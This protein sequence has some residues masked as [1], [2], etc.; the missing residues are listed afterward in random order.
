VVRHSRQWFLR[1]EHSAIRSGDVRWRVNLGIPSPGYGDEKVR[2]AFERVAR[3]AWAFSEASA[4]PSIQLAAEMLRSERPVGARIAVVPEVVAEAVGY[5]RSPLRRSDLHL[6]IDVGAT[7]LDVCGFILFDPNREEDQY[8]ILTARVERLGTHQLHSRRLNA[9]STSEWRPEIAAMD[10]SDPLLVIPDS[11]REYWKHDPVTPDVD[12]VDDNFQK[13]CV[14]VL[15]TCLHH[16]KVKRYPNSPAWK[17]GIPV[18]LCGGG[19][20]MP[21]YRRVIEQANARCQASWQMAHFSEISLPVPEA[22]AQAGVSGDLFRRLAV[23]YGLSFDR[24]E[25]GRILPPDTVAIPE[26]TKPRKRP[27]FIDKDQV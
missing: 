13:D 19:A 9:T 2:S 25:I 18:L 21:F 24:F 15:A 14:D 16:L 22:M 5:A 1:Q 20:E 17:L 11:I 10:L 6:L 3:G 7:T 27:S 26:P 23:A 8:T 12:H 4:P